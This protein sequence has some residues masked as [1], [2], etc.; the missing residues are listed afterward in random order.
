MRRGRSGS[1]GGN[2]TALGSRGLSN[3]GCHFLLEMVLPV[4]W[5]N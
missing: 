3:L 4:L 2:G 1:E 5:G